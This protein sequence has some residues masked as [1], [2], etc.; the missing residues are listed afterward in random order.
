MPP[1]RTLNKNQRL[2]SRKT[3]DAL[4][5]NGRS[6]S[7]YPFRVLY[8]IRPFE[9]AAEKKLQIPATAPSLKAGFSAPSKNFKKAVHR[10]RIKRLIKEA[11]RLNQ[12]QLNE[13]VSLQRIRLDIFFIYTGKDL[14]DQELVTGKISVVLQQL[15]KKLNES[16]PSNT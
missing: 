16:L 14:P 13:Y 5:K 3:I 7:V 9:S 1:P 15:L 2:K 8:I 4:F 11:Y 12:Q 6:F 10:N